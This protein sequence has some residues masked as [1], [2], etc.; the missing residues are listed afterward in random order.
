MLCLPTTPD[1][2]PL[3]QSSGDELSDFRVRLMGLT[4]MAGLAGLPQVHLPLLKV[5]GVPFGVSLIGPAGSDM[6]LL[7]LARRFSE[8]V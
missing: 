5:D 2:A 1:L 4:A 7:A 3:R 6:Q 8:E